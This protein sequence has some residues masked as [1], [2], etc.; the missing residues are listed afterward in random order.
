MAFADDIRT[1]N[2]T[3]NELGDLLEDLL[4]QAEIDSVEN[5][6]TSTTSTSKVDLSGMDI[7]VTIGAGYKVLILHTVMVSNATSAAQVSSIIEDVSTSSELS[8]MD[9][10]VWRGDTAGEDACISHFGLHNPGAGTFQYKGR[11]FTNTGTAYSN[12][13]KLSVITLRVS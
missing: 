12:Y 7:S 10:R 6:S 11:W 9:L 13:R 2:Y 5:T 8:A 4:V 3:R 1:E